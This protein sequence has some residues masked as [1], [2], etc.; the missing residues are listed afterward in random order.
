MT[1]RYE[2]ALEEA[3]AAVRRG[4]DLDRVLA[5]VPEHAD[6]LRDDLRLTAAVRNYAGTIAP[7]PAARATANQRLMSTLQ[8]ARS[9]HA[10]GSPSPSTG[11]GLA[12]GVRLPRFAMAAAVVLLAFA[13]FAALD[14]DS[15]PSVEAATI[16]GVVLGNTEGSLTVQ[17]LDALEQVTVPSD[18]AVSDA[19]GASIDLSRIE[20]GEVV[21]IQAQR[22]G[23]SVIARQVARLVANI[24]AWCNDASDRCEVLTDRLR[25]LEQGCE[26]RPV[27]CRV[28]LREIN[29]LRLRAAETARLE[30]LKGRCRAG[31]PTGCDELASFCREHPALCANLAP[32]IP[33]PS[34]DTRE[35]IRQLL[36]S[37]QQGEVSSCRQLAQL[38]QENAG[39]CPET[40]AR[41]PDTSTL[42][43]TT[44]PAAR[45]VDAPAATVVPLRSD[46]PPATQAP[47]R[48]SEPTATPAAQ[49][50]AAATVTPTAEPSEDPARPRDQRSR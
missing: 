17:T 36:Q 22:Q 7:S 46:S 24:E 11:R 28:T 3:L 27:A 39:V 43:P 32:L 13:V 40:P 5:R 19:T 6:A 10:S 42:E 23:E 50:P 18:A 9:T 15:G 20:P 47:T 4:E 29:Q 8:A 31:G 44:T 12:G 21:V 45:Q 1:M 2:D 41:R 34:T 14:R 30:G 33:S 16:E 37:C 26:A 48:P 49:R 35:R 38:C 25:D